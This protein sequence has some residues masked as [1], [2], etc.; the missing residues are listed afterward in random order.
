[1]SRLPNNTQASAPAGK[2][3]SSPAAACWHRATTALSS[4]KRYMQACSGAPLLYDRAVHAQSCL[5]VAAITPLVRKRKPT[6]KTLQQQ[7]ACQPTC[8]LLLEEA[9]QLMLSLDTKQA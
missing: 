9:C 6:P 4:S 7:P 1:M 8:A 3:R 2:Y 5:S